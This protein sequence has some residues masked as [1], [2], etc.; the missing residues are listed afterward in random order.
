MVSYYDKELGYDE[1]ARRCAAMFSREPG[2]ESEFVR[3]GFEYVRLMDKNAAEKFAAV[4]DKEAQS[5]ESVQSFDAGMENI[6]LRNPEN[7]RALIEAMLTP[8]IDS[9]LTALFQSEYYVKHLRVQKVAPSEGGDISFKW[10]K[11]GGPEKHVKVIL[12]LKSSA[13]TG[14]RTH[15]INLEQTAQLAAAGYDFVTL[16]DRLDDLSEFAAQRSGPFS[17]SSHSFEAGE[18]VIFQPMRA[19]HRGVE[20]DAGVR[21]TATLIILPHK[22]S[23]RKETERRDLLD[24]QTEKAMSWEIDRPWAVWSS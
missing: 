9:R 18:A 19:L 23:W 16:E 10:H 7:A 1:W 24:L 4:I 11:D 14:G 12:Y 13:E 20:P 22:N 21:Y 15:F 5:P 8:E 17:V 3:Q 6:T 2:G